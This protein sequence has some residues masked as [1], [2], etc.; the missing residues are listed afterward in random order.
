LQEAAIEL[1]A[2]RRILAAAV[3]AEFGVAYRDDIERPRRSPVGRL[4]DGFKMTA[5]SGLPDRIPLQTALQC[6]P[7][8]VPLLAVRAKTAAEALD[9]SLGSFLA[10]VREGA[11][12]QPIAIPGHSGLVLY[13][14]EALRNAWEA[15]KDAATSDANE[16]D[17]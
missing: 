11:M 13:D 15:L 7:R 4:V 10:L 12:P 2:S 5:K 3:L 14:F 16:W 8:F 9:I 6:Q 1:W 17:N